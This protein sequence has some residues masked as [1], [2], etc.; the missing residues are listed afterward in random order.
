MSNDKGYAH[1]KQMSSDKGCAYRKRIL[2][3]RDYVPRIQTL[4]THFRLYSTS[5]KLYYICHMSIKTPLIPPHRWQESPH[6][7][8]NPFASSK[9][10]IVKYNFLRIDS[11]EP[12]TVVSRILYPLVVCYLATTLSG[13]LTVLLSFSSSLSS[14]GNEEDSREASRR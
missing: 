1:G 11:P 9:T 12:L 8:P 2:E 7:Y 14:P 3:D 4:D 13:F 10:F 6:L 5:Q